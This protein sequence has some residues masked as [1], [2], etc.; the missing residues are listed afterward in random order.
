MSTLHHTT[1]REGA[2]PMTAHFESVAR[3]PRH[4]SLFSPFLKFLLAI[5]LPVGPNALITI[6]GRTSGLPRTTPVAITKVDGRRWIWAPW[7]EVN[8]VRNLRATGRA[9]ITV[10][11]RVEEVSAGEL[12]FD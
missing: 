7:G 10:R 2:T 6:R 8:W 1:P 4:V 3:A 11:N 9:T 12:D 5:G